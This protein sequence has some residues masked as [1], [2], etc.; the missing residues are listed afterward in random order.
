MRDELLGYYERELIFLRQLGAEFAG[1]Y[2]K[3]AG[4]LSLEPDKCEDP[5]VERLIE[6]FAFLAGRIHLKLDDELPEMTEAFLNVLYPHYLA[7]IP[8]M[9]IAHFAL[10]PEQ[11]KLTTAYRIERGA[12]LYSRPIQGTPCRFRTAYPV[13]LW[14]VEVESA[15]FESADPVSSRGRWEQAEIRIGL[16]CVNNTR[17]GEL[18]A[19]QDEK[20]PL[21]ESLRFYLSGEPQL[22]YPLYEAIFN[23]AVQVELRPKAAPKGHRS[24]SGERGLPSPVRLPASS[25]RTV[26]FEPDEGLLGYTARSFLGYR[27]LTEYFAFPDKFLFFDVTGL[28][29]AARSGFG[30]QFEIVIR[31]RDVPPPRAPVTAETFR[32]GCTP[33]VN[34]FGKIAE[35]IDLTQEQHEYRVVPDRHQQLATEVYSI[36]SVISDA[37]YLKEVHTFHPFYSF[38]H[39]GGR[40]PGGS[41]WH[42][43]RRPSQRRDD[44]GTEVYLSLVDLDFNPR[45]PGVE[46]ITAQTTCTNRDLPS[47]LPF[48][49]KEGDFEVENA[50]P[51]AR[52]RCLRKPTGAFRPPLRRGAHWR[53]ISHLSLNHLSLVS[54]ARDGSPEALREILTLYDFLDSAATRKQIHGLTRVGSRRVVRQTGSRIGT[55]FVRG[56]E[57]TLEFDEEQY[58]GGGVFLFASVLERF[59]GLYASINS[60]NQ[61]VVRTKQREGELRRWMPRAGNQNLL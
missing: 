45:V 31:L 19:A 49:S 52:V 26:G 7:P 14:P 35:P 5:H 36:D 12:I 6:A 59:L 20:A 2:P 32:L 28:D 61:L 24:G 16:R 8:S 33:I 11:G 18:K 34:L 48:G 10:D 58:V 54:D 25:L 42:A 1:K 43:T 39:A 4:R 15:C 40:E 55:G 53:L 56:I 23:H 17:L 37:P 60:F 21:I 22:V 38:G 41:F 29:L 3:V 50:G 30:E 47:R 44:Q 46:T 27:L 9:S 51:L 57:T 13:T